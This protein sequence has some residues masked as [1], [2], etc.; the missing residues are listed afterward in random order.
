M[1]SIQHR[2]HRVP[3]DKNL[4]ESNL[5]PKLNLKDAFGIAFNVFN[6]LIHVYKI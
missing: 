2:K 6:L 1:H 3:R 4:I 5:N